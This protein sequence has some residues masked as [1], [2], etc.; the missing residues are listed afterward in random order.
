MANGFGF[1]CACP[2]CRAR[3]LR[4]PLLLIAA[5]VLFSLDVIWRVWPASKTWPALLIVWGLSGVAAR[6]APDTGHGL[7]PAP[8][9]S[10]GIPT[11]GIQNAP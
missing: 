7:P 9:P 1:A 2:A 5:G 11:S 6:V 10:S 8:P 4:W 3:S